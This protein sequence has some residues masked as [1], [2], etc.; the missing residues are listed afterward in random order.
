[1]GSAVKELSGKASVS[2]H[3][4]LPV[5]EITSD[6]TSGKLQAQELNGSE[7]APNKRQLRKRGP[8]PVANHSQ[9]NINVKNSS[10]PNTVIKGRKVVSKRIEKLGRIIKSTAPQLET[11]SEKRPLS[12]NKSCQNYISDNKKSKNLNLLEEN[13]VKVNKNNP[14][15]SNKTTLPNC[16]NKSS[17]TKE[18]D[19]L[20]SISNPKSNSSPKSLNLSEEA[21]E[22]TQY[23]SMHDNPNY[24]NS[25]ILLLSE[26]ERTPDF[27]EL[28]VEVQDSD[29]D[30]PDP[31]FNR[32]DFIRSTYQ[33]SDSDED[34]VVLGEKK[35]TYQEITLDEVSFLVNSFKIYS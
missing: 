7:E 25:G 14:I 17:Q 18:L 16:Q 15:E 23:S 19:I 13:I 3:S 28:N 2:K 8:K 24:M 27:L 1:M 5:E 22:T 6:K 9:L 31:V 12:P 20:N 26:C 11:N 4:R 33:D 21:M 29:A 35:P 30:D 34:V 10:K 32:A